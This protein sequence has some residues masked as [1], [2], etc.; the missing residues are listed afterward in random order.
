MQ[1]HGQFLVTVALP[2]HDVMLLA[3]L[4]EPYVI[5]PFLLDHPL[6]P[7]LLPVCYTMVDVMHIE[8][9]AGSR[10]QH[11][12]QLSHHHRLQAPTW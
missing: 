12:V 10:A 8:A 4:A 2:T 5:S 7:P 9:L 3:V 11:M 6:L 1:L